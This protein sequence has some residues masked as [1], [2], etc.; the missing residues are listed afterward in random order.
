MK[1]IDWPDLWWSGTKRYFWQLCVNFFFHF[2][3]HY[4]TKLYIFQRVKSW[5]ATSQLIYQGPFESTVGEKG[6]FAPRIDF[7]VVSERD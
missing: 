3:V 2:C 5:L 7:H 4:S 1:V 6:E